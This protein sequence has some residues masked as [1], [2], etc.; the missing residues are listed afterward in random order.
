MAWLYLFIAVQW[1]AL[2]VSEKM[3]KPATRKLPICETPSTDISFS[4]YK[5]NKIV[6]P[7]L[8]GIRQEKTVAK[9][10]RKN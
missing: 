10:R 1:N 6:D 2:S 4:V 5:E 9:V 7:E 3:N 8:C